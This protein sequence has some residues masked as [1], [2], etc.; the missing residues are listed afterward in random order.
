MKLYYSATRSFSPIWD[1]NPEKL[2]YTEE[3]YRNIPMIQWLE[4]NVGPL[5]WPKDPSEKVHGEGWML[6]TYVE[7]EPHLKFRSYVWVDDAISI[8]EEEIT[9]F[10]LRFL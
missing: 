9:M 1:K 6:E 2:F 4:Q 3:D 10:H 7:T 5:T 8:T